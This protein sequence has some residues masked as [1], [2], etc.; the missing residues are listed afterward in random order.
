[1][2]LLLWFVV[3]L[4]AVSVRTSPIAE[5]V[6]VSGCEKRLDRAKET[7]GCFQQNET[8]VT[9]GIQ[10]LHFPTNLEELRLRLVES[11]VVPLTWD[12]EESAAVK[13][14]DLWSFECG[15]LQF[16]FKFPSHLMNCILPNPLQAVGDLDSQRQEAVRQRLGNG[17]VWMDV[18][19]E[20]KKEG[21]DEYVTIATLRDSVEVALPSTAGETEAAGHPL[22][23]L[24]GSSKWSEEDDKFWVSLGIGGLKDQLR[25]LFRRVFLSRLPS[26]VD[27]AD[28]LELQHVRGVIL[29]GPPG[30]G[31]TLIARALHKLL[32]RNSKL[33]IVNAP[34]IISKYIGDSEKNLRDVF[35]GLEVGT[36]VKNAEGG[37][38]TKTAPK[39]VK[40][41]LHILVIDEFESLFRRRGF[42]EDESSA[43][44]VYDGV[45]NTLLSLMDG[46]NSRN[47]ILVIGLTNRL[48][49]VDSALLRP[50]RFEV[51]M[52]VPSPDLKAREDI[53]FI[54]TEKLRDKGFLRSDVNL[55]KAARVTDGFSGADISGAVRSAVSYA[56]LRHREQQK[57]YPG[58]DGTMDSHQC[59]GTNANEQF[60]VG[61]QDLNRAI[62]DIS[63]TR[64][65][66]VAT[67]IHQLTDVENH[68]AFLYFDAGYLSSV[69]TIQKVANGIL[70]SKVRDWGVFL[71]SG[72]SGNGKTDMAHY[73]VHQLQENFNSL[74][75]ISCRRLI[76]APDKAEAGIRSIRRALSEAASNG[77]ALV[78]LDDIDE[79]V[80]SVGRQSSLLPSLKKWLFSYL[81]HP[82]DLVPEK[83]AAD[84]SFAEEESASRVNKRFLIL[85]SS[86]GNHEIVRDF[87]YDYTVPVKALD[88]AAMTAVLEFYGVV[89][90]KLSREGES[91]IYESYPPSLSFKVFLQLTDAAVQEVAAQVNRPLPL[92]FSVKKAE[93]TKANTNI[94]VQA[95]G[96]SFF[97]KD[98]T[99]ANLFAASIKKV[100]DQMGLLKNSWPSVNSDGDELLW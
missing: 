68:N 65:N 38:H 81:E 37:R 77:N 79:L 32:G 93:R 11:S 86:Q 52:E 36:S 51:I 3:L 26:L 84:L 17:S 80:N 29:H 31:K 82:E 63:R 34:D 96:K 92:F 88:R 9:L 62:V 5:I 73:L 97:V 46:V 55:Q 87:L 25:S 94:D 21:T 89:P 27:L 42:S 71:V 12:T 24:Y 44:A 40:P 7:F 13:E 75:F 53:F 8:S 66:T 1:M 16:S 10:G 60:V 90:V 91:S 4:A 64:Q 95:M 76:D 100:S 19:L 99:E 83:N 2:R 57:L 22:E 78:V 33:T 54:H 85:T 50:G 35:D 6:A 98:K 39:G 15:N 69:D 74:R 72:A 47:D 23:R 18:I 70:H 20:Q 59:D 30:N 56:L 28:T 61:E 41:S 45:T 49:A 67:G 48:D 14:E 43:K 58:C